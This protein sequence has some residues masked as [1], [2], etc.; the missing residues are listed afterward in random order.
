MVAI[1][2]KYVMYLLGIICCCIEVIISAPQSPT[3][4]TIN[5]LY[6]TTTDDHPKKPVVSHYAEVLIPPEVKMTQNPA[7]AMP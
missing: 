4:D 1:H 2:T 7:Y 5:P 6:N 3:Q